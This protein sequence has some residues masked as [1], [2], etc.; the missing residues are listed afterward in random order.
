MADIYNTNTA[1]GNIAV[2]LMTTAA[3]IGYN[4]YA[5]KQ[6]QKFNAQQAEL[7]RQFN[8]EEAEKARQ[9]EQEMSN[10]AYQR[11]YAD[12]A[13]A[14]LNPH[15]AGGSGGAGTPAGSAAS[16]TPATAGGMM[17]IN[18]AEN[19][20]TALTHA[21]LS[22]LEADTAMKNKQ[23][24]KTQKE[25]EYVENKMAL[26]TA[27]N[28]V[29]VELTQAQTKDAKKAAEQKQQLL[30]NQMIHNYYEFTT[31]RKMPSGMF[32]SI[33][34][35]VDYFIKNNSQSGNSSDALYQIIKAEIDNYNKGNKK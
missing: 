24:G 34:G 9:F 26:E 15:L 20:N 18:F 2:P 27:L 3:S 16:G 19:M 6:N 12:M 14:G 31:G 32:D 30:V 1:Y 17:P 21:Q 25:T 29:Q 4:I 23:S 11:A 10:T 33:F 35:K 13:A 7:N 22:N 8:A 28:E 5:N